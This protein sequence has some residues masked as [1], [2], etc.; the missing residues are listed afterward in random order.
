M[1]IRGFEI[2]H[3]WTGAYFDGNNSYVQIA[4][5]TFNDCSEG[6][7]GSSGALN[8]L[9]RDNSFE[10]SPSWQDATGIRFMYPRQLVIENNVFR[11]LEG[12]NF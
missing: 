10:K 5:N 4:D 8:V 7:G 1:R 12:R 9:I 3:A 6:I 11:N 2:K